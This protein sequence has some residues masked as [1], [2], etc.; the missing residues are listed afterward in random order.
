MYV[1]IEDA[2]GNHHTTPRSHGAWKVE[3]ST[4][5]GDFCFSVITTDSQMTLYLYDDD[6]GDEDDHASDDFASELAFSLINDADDLICRGNYTFPA[7]VGSGIVQNA[8]GGIAFDY[9]RIEP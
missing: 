6:L 1:R 9:E 7:N 3:P 8:Q 4:S 2:T 5:D